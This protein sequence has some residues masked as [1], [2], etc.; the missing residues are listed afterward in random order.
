MGAGSSA[1]GSGLVVG[2][3]LVLLGQQFGFLD[4]SVTLTA[5]I[6]L[7]AFGVVFAVVFGLFGVWLGARFMRKHAGLTEWK[8]KS[9][10]P[11]ASAESQPESEPKSN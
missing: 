11:S 3:C 1:A 9:E 2:I 7:I 8:A 4:L 10:P 6:Y 5:V